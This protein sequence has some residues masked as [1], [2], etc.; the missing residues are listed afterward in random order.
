[1]PMNGPPGGLCYPV[2]DPA[3]ESGTRSPATRMAR[4]ASAGSRVKEEYLR[5]STPYLGGRGFEMLAFGHAGV[6]VVLFPTSQ[7]RYYEYEDF[8]LIEAA[9]P[10]VDA[11]RVKLYCPAGRDGESRYNDGT[12]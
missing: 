8:R 7:G 1:M 10:L 11:G 2:P 3:A 6:P 9:A 4:M 5:W 12:H